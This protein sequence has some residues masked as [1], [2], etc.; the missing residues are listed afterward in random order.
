MISRIWKFLREWWTPD[1]EED[2][3]GFPGE[4]CP[5]CQ[6]FREIVFSVGNNKA[7][8]IPC[9]ACNGTGKVQ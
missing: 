5:L 1:D 9:P 7:W 4:T 8:H 6:G 3:D 2:A